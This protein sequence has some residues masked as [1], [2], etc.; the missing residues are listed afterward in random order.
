[1]GSLIAWMA[2]AWQGAQPAG[3][4]FGALFWLWIAVM[5]VLIALFVV[6]AVR[7]RRRRPPIDPNLR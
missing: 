2:I 3:P 4:G 1:M 6:R 7:P 5:V